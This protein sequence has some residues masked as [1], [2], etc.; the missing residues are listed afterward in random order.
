MGINCTFFFLISQNEIAVS[1]CYSNPIQVIDSACMRNLKRYFIFI[2]RSWFWKGHECSQTL[3][4]KCESSKK[5][6]RLVIYI[7]KKIGEYSIFEKFWGQNTLKYCSLFMSEIC[8]L[9]TFWLI[10]RP[11]ICTLLKIQWKLYKF[12]KK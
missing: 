1:K 12:T 2:T 4:R 6:L 3:K 9:Q 7:L 8:I 11:P 10:I 5:L